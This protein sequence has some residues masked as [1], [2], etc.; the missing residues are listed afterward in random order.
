MLKVRFSQVAPKQK[1]DG[2]KRK[3]A[4]LQNGPAIE[5]TLI[6]EPKDLNFWKRKIKF[7]ERRGLI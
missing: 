4:A 2:K 6:G 3:T 1:D 7:R 5:R